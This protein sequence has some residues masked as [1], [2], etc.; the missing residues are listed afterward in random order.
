VK[1]ALGVLLALI[2]AVSSGLT[3]QPIVVGLLLLVVASLLLAPR[4]RRPHAAAIAVLVAAALYG[5]RLVNFS[6]EPS[7]VGEIAL[8]PGQY[9]AKSDDFLKL[10]TVRVV[11]R[12]GGHLIFAEAHAPPFVGFDPGTLFHEPHRALFYQGIPPEP[13]PHSDATTAKVIHAAL[14]KALSGESEREEPRIPEGARIEGDKDSYWSMFPSEFDH[15]CDLSDAADGKYRGKSSNPAWQVS[16][17]ITVR[18]GKL[19]NV[20]ILDQRSSGFGTRAFAEMPALMVQKN[21]VNVDVISG[22]TRS[23]LL[24]RSAVFHACRS[25]FPSGS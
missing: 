25:S 8:E 5:G 18:A 3:L 12:E 13:D 20:E 23:S 16:V 17:E 10:I 2:G 7:E 21:E 4:A 9:T 22:A 14:A 11:V 24:I 15:R 1:R 6:V 19:A